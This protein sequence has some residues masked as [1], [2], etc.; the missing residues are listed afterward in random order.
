MQQ[1]DFNSL[2]PKIGCPHFCT[3]KCYA[4]LKR[5]SCSSF[6]FR[7]VLTSNFFVC[8]LLRLLYKAPPLLP[9]LL[10]STRQFDGSTNDET[11]FYGP[12]IVPGT[13]MA[14]VMQ[15]SRGWQLR[16]RFVKLDSNSHCGDNKQTE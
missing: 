3:I 14:S 4:T 7:L 15:R 5:M 12:A 11:T 8:N 2:P 6:L 9:L 10:P 13:S 1:K 16:R